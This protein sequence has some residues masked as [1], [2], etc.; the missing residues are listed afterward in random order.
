M[1]KYAILFGGDIGKLVIVCRANPVEVHHVPV[2]LFNKQLLPEVTGMSVVSVAREIA[3]LREIV[4][5]HDTISRLQQDALLLCQQENDI[6]R[7]ALTA[8]SKLPADRTEAPIVQTEVYSEAA[9]TCI[10]LAT[11]RWSHSDSA[12]ENGRKIARY[13]LLDS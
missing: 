13:V 12:P 4:K 7:G 3:T 11:K 8:E 10:T 6:L 9:P 5:K 2:M 1:Q